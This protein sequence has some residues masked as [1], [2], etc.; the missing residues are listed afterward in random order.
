LLRAASVAITAPG[1]SGITGIIPRSADVLEN[2]PETAGNLAIAAPRVSQAETD[3]RLIELWLHGRS[4]LTVA[5]Y[6]VDV[7]GF[8]EAVGK[9][10]RSLTIGDLQGWIDT[11]EGAPATRRRRLAAVKSLL[12]FA[13]RIG[14]VPFNAGAVVRLP[15]AI[16]VLAERILSEEQVVRMI[17]LE[18]NPRNHA[19]LRLLYLAALRVSEACALRWAG[20]KARRGAGQITVIGKRAKVRSI[21]LPASMYRELVVLRG[22]AGSDDPVFRSRQGGA[23]DPMSVQR[24]VKAAAIRAGLPKACSPHWL[25]HAHCSHALDRGANPALVRDTAGHA[26]LRVTSVY[27]HAQPAD[28]SARFLVG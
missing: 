26:D 2:R 24:V 4:G 13:T 28:S 8:F 5:A 17:A 7:G 16:N 20:C 18:R 1:D 22:D 11:L 23:L 27:S 6:G 14:Y 19:L 3:E 21:L 25:R 10:I 15:P 9:P 12:S